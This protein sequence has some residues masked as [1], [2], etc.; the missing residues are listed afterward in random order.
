MHKIIILL[1]LVLTYTQSSK[2]QDIF[3]TTETKE[4][5]TIVVPFSFYLQSFGLA[6][7]VD[8]ASKGFLQEQASSTLIGL[9]S[10]NGSKYIYWEAENFQIP[11]SYRLW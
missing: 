9:I 5:S 11:T 8:V 10:T 2:A 1:F 3:I 4:A 7:A 6:A